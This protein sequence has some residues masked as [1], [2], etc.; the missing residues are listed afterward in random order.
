MIST[1]A[2]APIKNIK[3]MSEFVKKH[4]DNIFITVELPQY[5]GMKVIQKAEITSYNECHTLAMN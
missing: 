1:F 2:I 3:N 5:M 4:K